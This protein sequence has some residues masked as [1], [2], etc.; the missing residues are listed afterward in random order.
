MHRPEKFEPGNEFF[1]H[2]VSR[3][4]VRS[5]HAVGYLKGRFQ[6]LRG[7]RISINKA[8]HIQYATSWIQACIRL[9]NFAM[10][11]E[12]EENVEA[13][14]FLR[15]GKKIMR[16]ERGNM[17]LYVKEREVLGLAAQRDQRKEALAAGKQKR[18][19]LKAILYEEL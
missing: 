12:R 10:M 6:S 7:L 1:N 19:A 2:R 9:H 16:Q 17:A 8:E 11:C 3:V 4:R 13:G 14:E 18:E 5:E 15:L